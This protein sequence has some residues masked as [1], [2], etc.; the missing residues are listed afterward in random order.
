MGTLVIHRPNDYGGTFRRLKV[1]VDGAEVAGLLPNKTFTIEVTAGVHE[2]RGRMDWATCHPLPV[3][4]P[5][6]EVVTV[7]VSLPL[8]S[9]VQS[10]VAR[11]RA[12]KTR[13]L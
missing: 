11:K 3:Q 1:Y 6:D 9:L 7:E 12:V 13:V 2:V 8:S 5:Q 10:F 4:V